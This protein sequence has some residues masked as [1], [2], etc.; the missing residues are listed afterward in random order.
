M[1]FDEVAAEC[2]NFLLYHLKRGYVFY[3]RHWS[4]LTKPIFIGC[5]RTSSILNGPMIIYT[6]RLSPF[7][8]K[9]NSVFKFYL[10]K[11]S[12]DAGKKEP[13][14]RGPREPDGPHYIREKNKKKRREKQILRIEDLL[15]REGSRTYPEPP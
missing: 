10:I 13:P 8:Q 1:G 15:T 7:K 14:W 3:I 2:M 5:T 4:T 9:S 11:K 6:S 12:P